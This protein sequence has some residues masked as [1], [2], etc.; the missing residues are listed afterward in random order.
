MELKASHF[1]VESQDEHP[2]MMLMYQDIMIILSEIVIT[3]ELTIATVI[4]REK[5][6]SVDSVKITTM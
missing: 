5:M 4:I 6:Y 3:V 2:K 1:F